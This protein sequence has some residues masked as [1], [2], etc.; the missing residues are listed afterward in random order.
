M[1]GDYG[2][3]FRRSLRIKE[4]IWWPHSAQIPLRESSDT[5]ETL[6]P[7]MGLGCYELFIRLSRMS[8]DII[9]KFLM[10]KK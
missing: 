4:C 1:L 3:S 10:K 2:R 8:Q 7:L 5:L 9:N 6:Y